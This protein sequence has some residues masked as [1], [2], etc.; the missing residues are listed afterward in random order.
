MRSLQGKLPELRRRGVDIAAV[1]VDKPE[2]TREHAAKQGF[3]FL[4][5]ADTEARVTRAYDLL[6]EGG[7]RGAD[8]SRPAEFLLDERRIVRWRNLT[9]DYKARLSGDDLLGVLDRL[10]SEP[11]RPAPRP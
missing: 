3:T 11:P 5:L 1:S 2:V 7:F 6:H 9:E 10:E 8:I 4:F